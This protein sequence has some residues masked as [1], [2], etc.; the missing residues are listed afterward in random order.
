MNRR[1]FIMTS[2]G[3]VLAAG[4]LLVTA[5]YAQNSRNEPANN[6]VSGYA[7]KPQNLMNPPAART[8]DSIALVWDKPLASGSVEGY[9]VYMNG[10][11]AGTVKRTDFTADNLAAETSYSFTVRSILKGERLSE[12]SDLVSASTRARGPVFD[13]T[14]YGAVGDGQTLNTKTIQKAIDACTPGGTLLFPKGVFMSGA[15]WLKSH[16]TVSVSE[17]AIL[18][19]SP[20]ADD[21]P[22]VMCRYGGREELCYSSLLNGGTL[23]E[24]G[25]EDVIITGPGRIDGNGT[26]LRVAEE[27]EDKKGPRGKVICFR[28]S[29][30]IYLHHFTEAQSPGWNIHFIYCQNVS[31]NDLKIHTL[32]DEQ[33]NWYTGIHNANGITPDSSRDMYIFNTMIASQ[34]DCIDIKSGIGEE[35][36]R[37][38]KPCENIRITGCSFK[39][40]I[41]VVVGS[42]MSGGV[43]N[44]LVRDCEFENVIGFASLKTGRGRG[45]TVE[46]IRY[47]NIRCR[48]RDKSLRPTIWAK[49]A[50]NIDFFYG[51]DDF[52]LSVHPVDEGTPVFK[53]IVFKD[54]VLEMDGMYGVYMVGYRNIPYAM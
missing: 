18:L 38:G 24:G 30:N 36:R 17:G 16:M 46:N 50:I 15:L 20:K 54:I 11:L 27:L 52:D 7:Y 25:L 3:A 26:K 28:N 23:R 22:M 4:W 43:R 42:E 44:V 35:G 8:V 6:I 29:R 51:R 33:G 14:Q 12:D 39:S 2:A 1:T 13:V 45:G 47:E 53:D 31:V 5:G 32:A 19:G 49:G 37:I 48:N 21:Y 41:G 34:D 10:R 9:N 40:G